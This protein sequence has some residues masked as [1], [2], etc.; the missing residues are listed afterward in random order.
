MIAGRAILLNQ[1][2]CSDGYETLAPVGSF[3]LGASWVGALDMG[4]NAEEWVADNFYYYP[5]EWVVNP[6]Q[7]HGYLGV[8]RGGSWKEPAIA[9]YAVWRDSEDNSISF[10]GPSQATGIRCVSRSVN[11]IP[12]THIVE[13]N[14]TILSQ[15]DHSPSPSTESVRESLTI[16]SGEALSSG[17]D[18]GVDTSEHRHDWVM[19]M[20][21]ATQMSYPDGEDWGVVYITVGKPSSYQHRQARDFSMYQTVSVNLRGQYGGEIVYLA[22]KEPFREDG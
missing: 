21:G 22:I 20:G 16:Y 18:M 2:E 17:F 19:N 14:A 9:M 4:G 12:S 13:P 11:G 6:F 10:R 7:R 15:S 8:T 5:S 1:E 3:P